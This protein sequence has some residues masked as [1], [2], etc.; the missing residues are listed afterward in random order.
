MNAKSQA[1][2]LLHHTASRREGSSALVM[3]LMLS[4]LVGTFALTVTNRAADERRA[5]WD[6]QQIAILE[7]AIRSARPFSK[8]LPSPLRL[9]VDDEA[10]VWV[11]VK[12]IN[13][14]DAND[15]LQATL[16]RNEQPGLTIQRP[17][18]G[19]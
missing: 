9:P 6:R 5:E 3:V 7:S 14:G 10:K 11:E 1:F 17:I 2:V 18:R 13:P 8:D 12:V 4:L 15:Q 19:Q 16:F